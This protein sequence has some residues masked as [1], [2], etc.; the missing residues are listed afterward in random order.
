MKP[1]PLSSLIFGD[2]CNLAEISRKTGIPP[3]TLNG[4]KKHPER[5]PLG[6]LRMILRARNAPPEERQKITE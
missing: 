1:R 4:Y 2:A 6:R 5:V 3:A